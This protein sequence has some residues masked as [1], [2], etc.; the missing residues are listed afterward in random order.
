METSE[1]HSE[2]L[3]D[4]NSSTLQLPIMRNEPKIYRITLNM[5]N[6]LQSL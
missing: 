4:Q 5:Q 3:W 6:S 2:I 1:K